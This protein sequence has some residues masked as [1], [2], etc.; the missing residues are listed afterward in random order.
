MTSDA[1]TG[2]PIATLKFTGRGDHVMRGP[3]TIGRDPRADEGATVEIDGDP[4]VSKSHLCVDI[5]QGDLIITDLGSSN[6][7]FLHHSAG[8]TAVPSDRWIPIPDG[9]EVEFGD[10]RMN[11]ER[12]DPRPPGGDGAAPSFGSAHDSSENRSADQDNAT[13]VDHEPALA[14]P[15]AT[16]EHLRA[17]DTEGANPGTG[18]AVDAEADLVGEAVPSADAIDCAQCDRSIPPDSKFCDGCGTPVMPTA[19]PVPA[20]G[21]PGHTVVLPPGG[22]GAA[23]ATPPPARPPASPPP[24]PGAPVSPGGPGPQYGGVSTPPPPQAPPPGQYAQA[25]SAQ[26]T[27]AAGPVFV[28]PTAQTSGGAGKKVL[29]VVGALLVVGAIA[30]G[31]VAVLGGDESTAGGRGTL[32]T[33]PNELDELWSTDV[34]GESGFPGLGETAVY[35][36]SVDGDDVVFTSLRRD[37]GDENWESVVEDADFGGVVGEFDEVTVVAACAFDAETVC[38]LVGLDLDDGDELWRE[39]LG[40]GFAFA[41]GDAVL[42]DDGE[43]L[44]LIDPATGDRL[45]R[46]RGEPTFT[47]FNA[48]LVDDEGEVSVYDDDLQPL[49]DPVRVDDDAVAV[50]FDGDRL[51]VAIGDEIEY[52]DA[53]GDAS[54]GPFLDGDVTRLLA[55][56]SSTLVVELGDE[57]VVY[58]VVDDEDAVERWSERGTLEIVAEPDGGAVVIVDAGSERVVADLETG[59]ERF[60]VRGDSGTISTFATANAFV[61]TDRGDGGGFAGEATVTAYDWET[62]DEIW[63]EDIDGDVRIDEIVVVVE[64]DGD[65]IAFG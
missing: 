38:A 41:S 23:T 64:T 25:S 4:L 8:E 52:V 34:V 17:R 22:L 58:D 5:D 45:E 24:Q 27:P 42:G 36:A 49:V 51:V 29:I 44:I 46:V 9:A 40:D 65:V 55:I 31:L 19:V 63:S 35:V 32:R 53:D 7:T 18:G 62:G 21:D 47:D 26:A 37:D 54:P 59:D 15:A 14:R 28:D 12:A 50:A 16:S 13:T 10:Q 3:V 48:L 60:D 6:G 11:I 61:V 1:E 30:A 33:I 2:D 39:P 56:D 57:V 20:E 43:G